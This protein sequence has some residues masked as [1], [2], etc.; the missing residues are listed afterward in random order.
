[1]TPWTKPFSDHLIQWGTYS[2]RFA[3]RD[4]CPWKIHND[5]EKLTIIGDTTLLPVIKKKGDKATGETG[6]LT[7]PYK[8]WGTN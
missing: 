7:L 4:L 3:A 8:T 6:M 2:D 5:F 1:M